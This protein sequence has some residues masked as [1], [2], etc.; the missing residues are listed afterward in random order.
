[1]NTKY[2]EI[3]VDIGIDLE[4]VIKLLKSYNAQGE[5]V[6]VNFNDKT[7]YS[8][9]INEDEIY[10]LITGFTKKGYFEFVEQEEKKNGRQIQK[11][12]R[13]KLALLNTNSTG[14]FLCS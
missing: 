14:L 9:N 4:E 11:I 13:K 5:K 1:M 7:L 2:K 8:D 12:I 10:K 3:Y 6:C